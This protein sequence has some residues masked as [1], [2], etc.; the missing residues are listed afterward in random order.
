MMT[1]I[2]FALALIGII[3]FAAG[4]R[5]EHTTLRWVG[6]GFVGAAFLTRFAKPRP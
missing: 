6:I 4:V 1:R 3:V 5:L 2:K